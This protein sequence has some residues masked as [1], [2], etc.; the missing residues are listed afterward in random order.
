M[1]RRPGRALKQMEFL[2]NFQKELNEY[3]YKT[4]QKESEN[5]KED[6]G[7]TVGHFSRLDLSSFSYGQFHSELLDKTPLLCAAITGA[8]SNLTYKDFKVWYF[9]IQSVK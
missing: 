5:V 2:P 7:P 8:A 3:V 9:E 4:V 1:E 6:K